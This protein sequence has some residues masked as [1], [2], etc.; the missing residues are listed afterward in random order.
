[1][2]GDQLV[3][4][5]IAGSNA[6]LQ[7]AA[8]IA[9]AA[10]KRIEKPLSVDGAAGVISA[11]ARDAT[12]P[13]ERDPCNLVSRAEA[14]AALEFPLV[15]DPVVEDSK[16]IYTYTGTGTRPLS[17]GLDIR[18]RNGFAVLREHA[19]IAANVGQANAQF[20]ERAAKAGSVA[21]VVDANLEVAP[22]KK[23]AAAPEPALAGPWEAAQVGMMEFSAVKKDVLI[24]ADAYDNKQQERA[25]KLVAAAMNKL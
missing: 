20:A 24:K 9:D 22:G 2:R 15:K 11:K 5:G 23:G 25:R 4:V 19:A 13:K 12:R 8:G 18:W 16:C 10:L 7:Q 21:K 14:E 17:V 3:T 6:T 1:M